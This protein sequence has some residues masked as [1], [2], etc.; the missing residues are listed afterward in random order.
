MNIRFNLAPPAVVVSVYIVIISTVLLLDALNVTTDE[1]WV[2][3]AFLSF[4]LSV[5]FELLMGV[6]GSIFP[7][8]A[9]WKLTH[10][11]ISYALFSGW[12]LVTGGLWYF[13]ITRLVIYVW[14]KIRGRHGDEPT[15]QT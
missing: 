10:P 5:I 15:R 4:P 3:V 2:I 13:Y 11:N 9:D 6:L 7:A 12:C 1:A 14:R 8:F